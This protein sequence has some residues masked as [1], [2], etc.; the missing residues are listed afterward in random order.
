MRINSDP[1]R[2]VT[3]PDVAAQVGEVGGTRAVGP[4]GSQSAGGAPT[5]TAGAVPERAP[6]PPPAAVAERRGGSRRGGDRRHRKQPVLVDMRVGQ[7][8]RSRRRSQDE[9][10]P[11]I[12]LKA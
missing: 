2:I 3:R 1:P 12:D 4:V 9:P 11:S 5:P 7:R 10:P 6:A 8:R